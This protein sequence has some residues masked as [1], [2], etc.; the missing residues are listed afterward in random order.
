MNRLTLSDLVLGL[1]HL[2]TKQAD[3]MEGLNA[4]TIYRPALQANHDAIIELLSSV[5]LHSRNPLSAELA[6]ANS[7]HDSLGNATRV[8]VQSYAMNPHAPA[9]LRAAAAR[10]I[11]GLLPAARDLQRTYIHEVKAARE[12]R[13]KLPDY[14]DDLRRF[15]TADGGTLLDWFTAHLDAA[16]VVLALLHQRVSLIADNQ[17]LRALNDSPNGNK[18]RN[19]ALKLINRFRKTVRD[20][21]S[22]RPDLPRALEERLFGF[23][24][25]LTGT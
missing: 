14:A 12:R 13:A 10:L 2:L 6:E 1:E 18:L 3:A 19:E 11:A 16:D 9:E 8:H 25:V 21:L 20:E 15:T 17:E 4:A 5:S 7:L 23:I 22:L 24:D